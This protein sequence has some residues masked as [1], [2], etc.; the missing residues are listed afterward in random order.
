MAVAAIAVNSSCMWMDCGGV[1]GAS[2]STTTGKKRVTKGCAGHCTLHRNGSNRLKG[3]ENGCESAKGEC[4]PCLVMLFR[5]SDLIHKKEEEE[6]EWNRDEL[7]VVEDREWGWGERRVWL[8]ER[9]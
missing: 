6:E 5:G 1:L 4:E 2:A 9:Q 7:N 8:S 3:G